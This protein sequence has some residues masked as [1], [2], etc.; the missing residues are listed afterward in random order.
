MRGIVNKRWRFGVGKR[1]A[2]MPNVPF[3]C[4]VDVFTE[5]HLEF[6]FRV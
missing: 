5:P 2:Q 1:E 4:C 6:P 3:C